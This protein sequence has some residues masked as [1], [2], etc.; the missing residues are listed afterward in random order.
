MPFVQM[1]MMLNS[2][3]NV[4]TDHL[5]N[6]AL[7]LL[8][9]LAIT[10]IRNVKLTATTGSEIEQGHVN[11]KEGIDARIE[12][13]RTVIARKT[14]SGEFRPHGH[15]LR[16]QPHLRPRQTRIQICWCPSLWHYTITLRS[17]T[18]IL[19]R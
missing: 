11:G 9:C 18:M 19:C 17:I 7:K 5:G 12:L 6:L 4:Y 15:Q 2:V 3:V 14:S 8:N 13:D 1:G 10:G 16:L